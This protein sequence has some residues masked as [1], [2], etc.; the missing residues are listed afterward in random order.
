MLKRVIRLTLHKWASIPFYPNETPTP[1]P[2]L[3]LRQQSGYVR[4]YLFKKTMRG[5]SNL[6]INLT[7]LKPLIKGRTKRPEKRCMWWILQLDIYVG[8]Y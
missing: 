4:K 7:F 2:G 3:Y 6:F 8:R 5:E 1:S